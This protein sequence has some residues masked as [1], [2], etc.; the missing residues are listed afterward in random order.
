MAKP[1]GKDSSTGLRAASML[2]VIPTLLVVSPLV[3]F[4]LGK[5]AEGWFAI[6]PWGTIVGLILGFVAAGKETYSIIRRVQAEQEEED[7]RR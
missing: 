1:S 4:F 7:K 6:A 5:L 3:G 2:L